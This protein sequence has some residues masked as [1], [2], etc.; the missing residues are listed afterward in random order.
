LK[1]LPKIN[2]KIVG[3]VALASSYFGGAEAPLPEVVI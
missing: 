1:Y 2:F 3:T